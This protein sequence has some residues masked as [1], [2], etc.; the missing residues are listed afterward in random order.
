MRAMQD[1][2]LLQEQ[3]DYY[4]ARAAEYDEWWLRRGRY[5]RGPVLNGKWFAESAEV[6]SAL[7]VLRPA[8]R[9]WNWPAEPGSGPSS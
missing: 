6:R 9:I 1:F 4:R 5:D 7:A 2:T 8:G 3:L